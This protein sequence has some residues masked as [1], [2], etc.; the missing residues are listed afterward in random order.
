[1]DLTSKLLVAMPGMEDPRFAHSVI[2]ICAHSEEGAMGLIVNRLAP[3]LKLSDVM[4]RNIETRGDGSDGDIDLHIGGPVETERGFVLHSDDYTS[5]ISTLELEGGFAMTATQDVLD[6]IAAGE[7]PKQALLMLGYAGWGANQLETELGQN[8]WLTCDA[9]RELVFDLS[10]EQKWE[11]ALRS[12]GI[13]PLSLS[14][15]AGRA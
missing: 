4:E 6:S 12:V 9:T 15:A 11:A 3:G 8:G 14:A 2:Y 7:G 10:D 1:M 13:E 5:V